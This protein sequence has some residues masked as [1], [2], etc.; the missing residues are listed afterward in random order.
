MEF[1]VIEQLYEQVEQ[2]EE[3]VSAGSGHEVHLVWTR[4]EEVALEVVYL[5]VGDV[6]LFVVHLL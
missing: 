5:N 1:I 4:V 3:V 2:R 6:V